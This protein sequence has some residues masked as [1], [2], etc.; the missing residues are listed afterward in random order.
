[1]NHDKAFEYFDL[2]TNLAMSEKYDRAANYLTNAIEILPDEAV[3]YEQRGV[4]FFHMG[5]E[6]ESLTDFDRA[7][8]LDSQRASAWQNRAL[9]WE[10]KK[11]WGQ[12]IR[13]MQTATLLD[14]ENIDYLLLLCWYYVGDKDWENVLASTSLGI[15][16]SPSVYQFHEYKGI[17]LVETKRYTEAAQFY[18]KTKPPADFTGRI[19]HFI[20]TGFSLLQNGRHE[21]SIIWFDRALSEDEHPYAYNNRGYAKFLTGRIEAGLRDINL[22]LEIDPSNSYAYKNRA[23]VYL[24]VNKKEKAFEDLQKAVELGYEEYYGDEVNE[25]L[26]ANF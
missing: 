11:D 8:L 4:V 26:K 6:S 3:F 13:D 21:E 18:L 16:K 14:K 9:F 5:K 25:L 12:A 7:I 20:S 15:S 22:S 17:A 24:H 10:T 2:A 19:N 23:I 1:M